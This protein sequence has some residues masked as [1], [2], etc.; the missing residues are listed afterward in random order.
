MEVAA[1]KYAGTDALADGDEHKILLSLRCSAM[2]FA[3]GRQVGI[4]FNNHT[5]FELTGE[6]GPQSDIT[7]IFQSAKGNHDP[8]V[9]IDD[10]GHSYHEPQQLILRLLLFSQQ[11]ADFFADA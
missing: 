7:P 9:D 6:Q 10:C 8:L 4:I 1:H 3:L 2:V 5:A 11:F